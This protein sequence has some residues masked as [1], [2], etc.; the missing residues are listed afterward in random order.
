MSEEPT[1]SSPLKEEADSR[2]AVVSGPLAYSGESLHFFSNFGDFKSS[3]KGI[4]ESESFSRGIAALDTIL[5]IKKPPRFPEDLDDASASLAVLEDEFLCRLA[6]SMD[7]FKRSRE[8]KE[9]EGAK[10]ETVSASGSSVNVTMKDKRMIAV[11]PRVPFHIPTI[12]RPQDVYK[13]RVNNNN[14]PFDHVWLDTGDGN[15]IHPLLKLSVA[16]FV[17]RK[18]ESEP[19]EPLHLESTPFKLVET[20]NDFEMVVAKLRHVDELAVDLEHNHYRSFQG[21][22]CL[23]QISTRDEDFV[24]DTLKLRIYIGMYLR[25]IFKDPS[26]R[27]VMHGA[28]RDI[29]WLQRDFG[30]YI[31]N[32]F[33]TG[34][35]FL[36][37][38]LY[39]HQGYCKWKEIVW[40]IFCVTSVELRQTRSKLFLCSYQSADWRLRPI[41]HEM[42]K[43]SMKSIFPYHFLKFIF[44]D[45]LLLKYAR[46]DTHYLL[47]IYDHMKRILLAESSDGNDLILEVYK[48]SSTICLQLYKKEIFTNTSFLNIYGLRDA[49][50]NATQLAVVS[51]LYQWRDY[52]AREQDESTGYILPNK[53]LIEI[54]KQMPPL[55]GA[56]IPLVMFKHPV[57]EQHL[58]T[59]I[60]IIKNS[61]GNAFSF[62][63][64]ARQL[65][66]ERIEAVSHKLSGDYE[67]FMG[68][69]RHA[70]G[71]GGGCVPS[72]KRRQAATSE[73]TAAARD[74]P[75]PI[76]DRS[77]VE[78]TPAPPPP[79][80]LKVFIVFYSMYG[81]VEGLAKRMKTGVDGVEG[82]E[83]VLYRVPE[84][85][86]AEILEQMKAPPNDLSIPE[87]SAAELVEADGILF[88]FP[89]RFGSMAA[90]MKAFFDTTGQLWREQKL[91]GK[92]A[93]FFVS[94][95]T[96]GGGQETTAWTAITQLAHHGMLFVPIGYTFGAGMFKMDEIRGGSPYGAG[97]F[98]GDG[99]RTPSDV[100]YAFAEHQGRYMANV[101]KTLGHH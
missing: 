42:L 26:K 84:T 57:V 35:L 11:P 60:E 34:Q 1:S 36:S 70:M 81:H 79:A 62:E 48:R 86:P 83:G 95:G 85:L 71:K 88:G 40:S 10:D 100:E 54:A 67:I 13:I 101:V 14:Q 66:L 96:Q 32:L 87:I 99:T 53:T 6:I 82:V 50:L 16:D 72:K 44:P 55:P 18:S 20:W 76:E 31:C 43:Y 22:T 41:P 68:L 58:S 4:G 2:R 75:I 3:L 23:M 25:E 90:Q 15:M 78:T 21:L 7:E 46:E 8:E 29:I 47:Y 65:K 77:S 17:D 63:M 51:A 33:D 9:A 56:L 93:G 38:T 27:K 19:V 64:I 80:K 45:N 97:V 24:I 61:I 69:T 73:K 89:T 39:R 98:A 5:G 12:P 37:F 49:D 52:I 30:I 94:T 28:D 74:A 92:P 91:A 59:V